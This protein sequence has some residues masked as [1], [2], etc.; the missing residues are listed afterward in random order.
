MKILSCISI[1]FLIS[2]FSMKAQE[3]ITDRPDQTESPYVVPKN[4]LQAEHGF[5][6]DW[7]EILDSDFPV[8]ETEF[9]IYKIGSTLL[10]YGINQTFE[11]RCEINPL[12]SNTVNDT[13]AGITPVGIG[14]KAKLIEGDGLKPQ[15]AL[16]TTLYP[17]FLSTETL[18]P[19]M[20]VLSLRLAADHGIT[21][22]MGVSYNL[23]IEMTGL[24]YPVFIYTLS[25]GFAINEKIGCFAEIFGNFPF[26]NAS[27]DIDGNMFV[28]GG[29]TYKIKPT[30]QA[31]ISGGII[32]HADNKNYFTGIGI[33]YLLSLKRKSNG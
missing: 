20:P 28:D 15:V 7:G 29:L 8:A 23:G 27:S 2:A 10:R 18:R 9:H 31:D 6:M 25:T 5:G 33:S 4:Y 26:Q 19:E 12:I 11:V 21:E 1:L 24:D 22:W 16:L 3:I 30:I 32:L 17:A 13:I 14:L